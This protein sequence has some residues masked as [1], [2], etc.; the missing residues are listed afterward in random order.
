MPRKVKQPVKAKPK[1][2][3]N[4]KQAQQQTQNVIVNVS[5]LKKTKPRKKRAPKRKPEEAGYRE[6]PTTVYIPQPL[7]IYGDMIKPAETTARS[8]TRPAEPSKT[9]P[10]LED[11]GIVGT[12]GRGVEII[13]VPTKKETL[14]ELIAPVALPEEDS[15]RAIAR[16]TVEPE[17]ERISLPD[18]KVS[19]LIPKKSS[20][21]EMSFRFNEPTTLRFSDI[22]NIAPSPYASEKSG[23]ESDTPIRLT[24][25]NFMKKQTGFMEQA[26]KSYA[27]KQ[28]TPREKKSY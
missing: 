10:I 6:F 15:G 13:D 14:A 1:K 24:G 3:S 18:D 16:S 8:I 22:E 11:T 26:K 25:S 27:Q 9:T 12:E 7:S 5:D 17:A 28:T 2:D 20:E 21:G 4:L 23:N 19:R